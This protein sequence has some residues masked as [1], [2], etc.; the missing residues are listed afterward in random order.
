MKALLIVTAANFGSYQV[1]MPSMADCLEAKS[2]VTRQNEKIETLCIP[3]VGETA[4]VEKFFSIFMNIVSEIKQL[5]N[6]GK[7]AQ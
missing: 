5:E 4:K 6:E 7:L 2:Q 1:E 3:A